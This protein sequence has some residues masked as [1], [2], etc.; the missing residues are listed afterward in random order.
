MDKSLEN[1]VQRLVIDGYSS[2]GAGVARLDGVVVFVEG[3]IRHEACDVRIT[4]V[5]RSAMWGQVVEAVVPSPARIFPKC[6]HYTKCGGC[7]FRHM[8]YAEELEAKRIRVEDALHRIGGLSLE[9][10]VILGAR[11][12][13]RYR[14]KAQ[15]PVAAGPSIGFY[16]AR[17]HDVIDV[18]DCLLQSEAS[19]HLRG[20]VKAWMER[21]SIPAYDERTGGGLV[22]H[23]YVRTA[24]DGHSLCCLLV[25]GK[26]VPQ[27]EALVEALRR[28]DPLLAGVVLGVNETRS[29]V[30]LG[31]AYRTLWGRDYLDDVLC[32]LTFRVSVPSFYQVNPD[33][34]ERLYE[35]AVELAGLTGAE[36]VLDLYCGIGTISLVMARR[37]GQVIGCEV[38]P[39]AVE[40]A[41]A[42]ARRNGI[43]NARFLCADAGQAAAELC[44]QG[45]RPDVICVDPPRKG[46]SPEVIDAIADMGPA[47]V[48]YVSCDPGTL[49]RDLK[50]LTQRGYEARS[51]TAVDMF[52]RTAHVESVVL[53]TRTGAAAA[54]SA[55]I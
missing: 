29:N 35:K 52:P 37:A 8:N 18:E 4:K 31:D 39:Q 33:Q 19:A 48:V 27:E 24:R 51:A 43:E 49:A 9:V 22:R 32:G 55:D 12:I 34:A 38:V 10:P 15:Y 21:F 54:P 1:T 20:A 17:S 23:V 5:G 47:R 42:N 13:R 11:E 26:S 2:T 44:A 46:L 41:A 36:T 6:L 25:N 14:N 7:S 40:D 3:G 28:A 16:R 45:V 50:L 30:I 53:M